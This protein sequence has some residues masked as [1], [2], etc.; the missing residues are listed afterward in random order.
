MLV[1]GMVSGAGGLVG[2]FVSL[3]RVRPEPEVFR[4]FPYL[5][6]AIIA[7]GFFVV[8]AILVLG[9]F[10]WRS[11]QETRTLTRELEE[12]AAALMWEQLGLP[13]ANGSP[14][15]SEP[16]RGARP[17]TSARRNTGR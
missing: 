13:A 17:L 9:H 16:D 14:P 10:V 7:T 15:A 12:A 1:L 11:Y 2:M 3:S 5:I 4:Q 6:S 8:G